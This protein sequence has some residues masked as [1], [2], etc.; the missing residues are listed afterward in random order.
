[1]LCFVHTRTHKQKFCFWDSKKYHPLQR[2]LVSARLAWSVRVPPLLRR[3]TL[4]PTVMSYEVDLFWQKERFGCFTPSAFFLLVEHNCSQTRHCLRRH[5][6]SSVPPR[7]PTRGR[8]VVN[9]GDHYHNFTF[10]NHNKKIGT[11]YKVGMPT[12]PAFWPRLTAG[13][14]TTPITSATPPTHSPPSP[15]P[16]PPPP[17]PPSLPPPPSSPSPSTGTDSAPGPLECVKPHALAG[18]ATG[19]PRDRSKQPACQHQHATAVAAQS[20]EWR[21]VSSQRGGVERSAA[22]CPLQQQQQ[23]HQW[24][25]RQ[26][27]PPLV[28]DAR[29]SSGGVR[30]AEG[31][32]EAATEAAAVAGGARARSGEVNGGCIRNG[33]V[34]KALSVPK[35]NVRRNHYDHDH[36]RHDEANS[37]VNDGRRGLRRSFCR[38]TEGQ[39]RSSVGKRRPCSQQQ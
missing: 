28:L 19:Q 25:Q 1:M 15:T 3:H 23:Q 38:L 35:Y 33:W 32:A 22:R 31:E 30:E 2:C 17:L 9:K 21:S 7:P 18:S 11:R 39:R 8:F 5:R 27:Y 24:Q 12:A 29:V 16:P 20:P 26:Q 34:G 10:N 13:A 4:C 37:R 36:R 14:T 6:P